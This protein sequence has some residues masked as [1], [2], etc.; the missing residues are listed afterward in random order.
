MPT[1]V[2]TLRTEIRR[3][4]AVEV[5]KALWRLRRIQKQVKALRLASRRQKLA[6]SGVEKGVH[7][8][9]DR[10]ATRG[11]RA[12][13]RVP[14]RGPRVPPRTIRAVRRRLKLT[15]EQFADLVG[16]S[17]GSIFGW[18]TGRTVPRG[19][20]RTRLVELK[21][22]GP[23]AHQRKTRGAAGR[24]RQRRRRARR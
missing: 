1:L 14:A 7:R 8:L 11:F 24:G 17:P 10:M 21:K 18:E 4:A 22:A 23:R 16:V 20:S 9:S 6:L 19:G 13:T 12:G 5:Q 15:R 2:A 3:L